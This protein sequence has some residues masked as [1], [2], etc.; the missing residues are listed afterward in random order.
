MINSK[1]LRLY[2]IHNGSGSRYYRMIPQLKHMQSLGH[3]V[4]LTD[5]NDQH[6]EQHIEWSDIVILEMVF[7]TGIVKKCKK[8]GKKVVFECDDL[9]HIVPKTHYSYDS[10]KGIRKKVKM[11][12][13]VISC[14]RHCDG[15]ITTNKVLNRQYGW[16]T[17][18]S[19]VFDNYLDIAHWLKEYKLNR[20][21]SIR[22]LWAGSTSHKG[23]LL[24][25]KPIMKRILEKYPQV[26]FIYVGDGGIKTD[27]LQARFIYG[28]DLWEGIP[29]NRENIL[30]VPGNIWPYKLAALQADIAIA[31]LEKNFFN[32]CKSQCKRLEYGI[33]K[34]PAIYSAHHYTDVINRHTGI[35]A[36]TDDDW[37]IGLSELIENKKLR[38]DIADN[39][40]NDVMKNWNMQDHVDEWSEFIL[41]L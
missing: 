41:S 27:D 24:K 5:S 33:N 9:V 22:L 10:V 4:I 3:E 37:F 26:K 40:Y 36:E 2:C 30:A 25:F 6:M 11:W 34:I 31:P 28:E 13:E 21:D 1:K 38:D 17:K 7:S 35:L 12:K 32:K 18:K 15:F 8:L 19:L 29:N 16:L 20:S 23:D 39:A 14:L